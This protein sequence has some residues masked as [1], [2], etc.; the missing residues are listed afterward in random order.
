MRAVSLPV[1]AT[2]KARGAGLELW[3]IDLAA[4]LAPDALASLDTDE[5]QRA[6]RFVFAHHRHRFLAAHAAVRALLAD[7]LACEPAEIAFAYGPH[8]K[9][10]LVRPAPADD[11]QRPPLGSFNL[12]H[13]DD[14]GLLLWCPAGGDWGIDIECVR[15]LS[16]ADEL[17]RHVFT[18]DERSDWQAL[19]AD[20]RPRAFLQRWACKEACL[21]AVGSGLSIAPRSFGLASIDGPCSTILTDADGALHRIRVAPLALAGAMD[22][23][24]AADAVAAVAWRVAST[25]AFTDMDG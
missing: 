11:P 25:A 6:D 18:A 17:A 21:K 9:P 16:D 12:S 8:G 5:R 24:M 10:K 4:P 7:A 13:S 23:E 1:P 2:L 3:Q 15:A 20:A 14:L 22:I 19:P